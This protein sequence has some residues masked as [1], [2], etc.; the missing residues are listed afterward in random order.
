MKE[1]SPV[2]FKSVLADYIY[3]MITE[4]RAVGY[5]NFLNI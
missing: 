2:T 5:L 3:G 4:K 1:K